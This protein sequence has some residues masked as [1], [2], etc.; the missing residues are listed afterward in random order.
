VSINNGQTVNLK[1]NLTGTP[2]AEPGAPL[3][4]TFDGL[5]LSIPY[6][7]N[8]KCLENELITIKGLGS[9]VGKGES[10]LLTAGDGMIEGASYTWKESSNVS[11][12]NQTGNKVVATFNAAGKAT[13]DLQVK[14]SYCTLDAKVETKV[15]GTTIDVAGG[16]LTF[17]DYNLGVD[18]NLTPEEYLTYDEKILGDLYQWGR[19]KDGHEQRDSDTIRTFSSS[20]TPTHGKFIVA[21][22]YPYDWHS[23]KNDNLWGASRMPNDPCPDGWKVPTQAQ[24]ASLYNDNKDKWEWTDSG[25]L[26]DGK[27]FLPAA[28]DHNHIENSLRFVDISGF[29]WSSTVDG[30]GA[31]SL[32]FNKDSIYT[33][34]YYNYRAY[35]R[36]VRCVAA[37]TTA[38]DNLT[39][40]DVAILGMPEGVC[41]GKTLVL[42]AGNNLISGATYKWIPSDNVTLS[43]QDGNTITATFNAVGEA[44]VSVQVETIMGTLTAEEVGATVVISP[45]ITGVTST[46][47]GGS[48][49]VTVSAT[50]S[51][52]AT[53]DWYSVAI[54]GKAFLKDTTSFSPTVSK[55]M[56]Y[57]VEARNTTTECTSAERTPVYV[58]VYATHN[59]GANPSLS[60]T[61]YVVGNGGWANGTSGVAAGDG[62]T[63]TL[64]YLYQWGRKGGNDDKYELR[65]SLYTTDLSLSDTP[66]HGKFIVA[67][68]TPCDWRSGQNPNLWGDTKTKFDPC[69]TG[70][71]VPTKEQW[72]RLIAAFP[73]STWTGKGR[74]FGDTIFLPAAGLRSY[75]NPAL[76]EVGT[77][78]LYWSC[79]TGPGTSSFYFDVTSSRAFVNGALRAYGLSIRCVAE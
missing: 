26:I 70:W 17:M 31:Y 3:T 6:H 60:D 43:K 22:H 12:S 57:Y 46:A 10:V 56:I 79:S 33:S 50:A 28:G 8:L 78:G 47:R 38:T 20:D 23:P 42:S 44:T 45:T 25:Y 67:P 54:G 48:G 9:L 30:I 19:Q 14:T 18:P 53:I 2:T 52:G 15:E 64:G 69:P 71:K 24:W 32:T 75:F 41:Q 65:N 4:A 40:D 39:S 7:T 63:G 61:I 35:G 76:G 16:K 1:Y 11:L 66:D 29:Y 55:S 27:L 36:S 73:T 77:R 51:A 5:G 37:E 68:E 59:L 62:S 58:D 13:I 21:P 72:E 74:R 49:S 34:N